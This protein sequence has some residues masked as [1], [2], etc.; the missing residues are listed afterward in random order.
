MEAGTHTER[1]LISLWL[2]SYIAPL[3]LFLAPWIGLPIKTHVWGGHARTFQIA[4]AIALTLYVTIWNYVILKRRRM[5]QKTIAE[6][7]AR[8]GIV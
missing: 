2:L 3:F 5:F 4:V 7:R 8:G 1:F 6:I